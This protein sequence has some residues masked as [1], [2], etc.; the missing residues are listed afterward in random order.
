MFTQNFESTLELPAWRVVSEF[1]FRA[2]RREDVP[3]LY[4]MLLAVEHAD[5]RDLVETL[6]DLQREFDDP[7][8]NPEIDSLAAFALDGQLAG[9]ARTF[10]NPQPEDELRCWLVVEI[11]PA[12]RSGGLLDEVLLDWAEERGRQRL[13]S[14]PVEV[15]RMLRSGL[16]DTQA[17]RQAQLEQRRFSIVRY[18]YRMQRDL[19]EPIPAVELPGDLA[20]RVYTPDLSEAVHAAFNE[21]FR[22][23]WSF[24]PVSKEDWQMFFLKRS[25]FRPELT[26]V[27]MDDR[28]V[29]GFSFNCV[30]EAENVRR[31]RSEGWIAELAVRRTWRKRGVATALLCASMHAF[32]AE[33]LQHA[34]LG[35]D[36]ENPTGALRV[37]ERVGFKPVKRYIQFEKRVS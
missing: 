25:S 29:A 8:S 6:A 16:Q 17:Q 18:F 21:A 36:A 9:F 33:G 28:E 27:V 22:D 14:A 11:H 7:W 37:Y 30:S 4:E 34:L 5:E 19:N 2:L 13:Q 32:K 12:W 26:Y 15:P 35:V 3:A 10:Q 24:E 20:L 1:E 31:G 23:H